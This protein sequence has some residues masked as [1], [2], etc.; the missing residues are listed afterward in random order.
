LDREHPKGAKISI[1]FELY[2]HSS[3]G[4]A[5]SAILANFGGPGIAT[6]IERFAALFV[7]GSNLDVHDL[8]LIDD[9]G[10]GNSNVI[11]CEP[12]Q[13]GT[14]PFAPSVADCAKQL[15]DAASFYGAGDNSLDVEAVRAALGYDKV[16]Y[17]GG[18]FGGLDAAAYATRFGQH[19]R[20]IILDAPTGTP[21]LIP[22]AIQGFR[23]K[24]DP[25]MVKLDCERSPTCSPDH[26]FPTLAST[27]WSPRFAFIPCRGMLSML[28]A[29]P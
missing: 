10:T 9:R 17:H 29:I 3:P 23:A 14:E 15:G 25:L 19:V 6:N 7:Y 22:F 1:Y 11:D 5:E 12:L 26:P 20:S 24:K 21:G 16:D 4:P 8:L 27:Y 13:H 18:S 28:E 2:A